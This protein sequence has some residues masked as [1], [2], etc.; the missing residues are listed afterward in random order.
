MSDF[1]LTM[2]LDNAAFFDEAGEPRPEPEIARILRRLADYIEGSSDLSP[3]DGAMYTLRDIN[4]NVVGRAGLA[5]MIG[6]NRERPVYKS[7]RGNLYK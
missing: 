7:Y 6:V 1:T 2:N 4:G 3:G 5:R